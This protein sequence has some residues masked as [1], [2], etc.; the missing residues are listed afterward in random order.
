MLKTWNSRF[1]NNMYIY[2]YYFIL[3][4]SPQRARVRELAYRQ[5]RAREREFSA[6]GEIVE[7]Q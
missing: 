2:A 3:F 1:R 4:I 6:P 7:F 5:A